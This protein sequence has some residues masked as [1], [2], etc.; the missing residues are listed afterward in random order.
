MRAVVQRVTKGNVTV[1]GECTGAIGHGLVVLLGVEADDSDADLQYMVDK[2]PNL[3]VFEDAA[4]KMNCSLF[5]VNGE[6]LVVS[7]FTLCGDCRKGRRPSFSSAARPEE[8]NRL[9]TLFIEQIR[10]TGLTVATG[11]FQTEMLVEIHNNGPVTI[12]LDSR[13]RF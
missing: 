8:A 1:N 3:R 12:M 7:Q 6:M 10:A 2:I 5:D 9:Y 4:G 11:V 13:R